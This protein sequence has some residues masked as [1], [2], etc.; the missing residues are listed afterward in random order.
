[1]TKAQRAANLMPNGQPK[2]IRVYDFEDGGYDRYT[3]VFT[4]HYTHK[5]GRWH[6]HIGMTELGGWTHGASEQQIDTNKS[7]FAPMIGRKNHLGRRIEF[8]ALPKECQNVVI[9][10]YKYLWDIE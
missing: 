5:T 8:A 6:W 3:V 4:G 9:E 10:Q 2:Y 7:G 1:M